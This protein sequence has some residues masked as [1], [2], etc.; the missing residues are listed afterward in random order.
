[1]IPFSCSCG[2]QL[3]AEEQYAG[4]SVSCPA[5]GARLT[6]PGGLAT[7][8]RDRR[9]DD[10]PQDA[11][12][13]ARRASGG[14]GTRRGSIDPADYRNGQSSATGWIIAG[15]SAGVVLVATIAV[16]LIVFL[17]GS[18]DGRMSSSQEPTAA[19]RSANNLRQ[20]GIAMHD[21]QSTFNR[22]PPAVVYDNAGKP[23]YSWRVLL[24]P[25]LEED[26]LYREFHLNEPWDGE[27][28][29][30]LL[31]RMPKVYQHPGNTSQTDTHYLV[32]D[33]PHCAFNSQISSGALRPFNG[34]PPPNQVFEG[35]IASSI[36]RT[37][38]DGTSNT[39]MVIE[40]DEAVPWTKPADL[41]FVP[42]QPLPKLGGLYASD[43]LVVGLAD[44]STRTLFRSKISDTTLR[45]AITADGA[46]ILGPDW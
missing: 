1:M 24:L 23:L 7:G 14:P 45:A 36:P 46:E 3:Q 38:L 2:K 26:P 12:V 27:H 18:G 21:Y 30:T 29:K 8:F 16:L 35:G 5:C 39:I 31:S 28:N 20:I 44:G 40:A 37:F 17:G 10:R 33:S 13:R 15:I 41:A 22:L 11:H 43:R 32:F 25:Y 6:I 9:P 34:V 4:Q 42:S 19:A